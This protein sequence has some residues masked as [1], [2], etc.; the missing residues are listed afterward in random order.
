MSLAPVTLFVY[1]RIDHTK[2][3]VGA[4]AKKM[5]LLI[6]VI[7]QFFLMG[8]KMREMVKKLVK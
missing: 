3:T 1:N 7:L 6:K 2:K 5:I 4:F 8:Q